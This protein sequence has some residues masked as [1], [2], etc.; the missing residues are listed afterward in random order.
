M[1]WWMNMR[2]RTLTVVAVVALIAAACGGTSEAGAEAG[3]EA[4]IEELAGLDPETRRGRLIELAGSEEAELNFYTTM[5]IDD[6]G[7]VLDAFEDAYDIEVNLYRASASS[8]LQRVLQE[9]EAGFA[10]ADA[11]AVGAAEMTV[12]DEEGVLEELDTP[13]VD[14][15]VASAVHATWAGIY[16]NV[17]AASWNDETAE[18]GRAPTTWEEVLSAYQGG[19]VMEI[20]DFDWFGALVEDYFVGTLGYTEDEAVDLFKSAATE[21]RGIEGHSLMAELLAGG[22]FDVAASTYQHGVER[23]RARGAPISWEPAV[24]P[25]VMRPTGIGLHRDAKAPAK[26]LLFIDFMLTEAQP[27]LAELHRTPANQTVDGGI[28]VEYEVI[29]VSDSV[30]GEDR[31]KWEELYEQVIGAGSE[32]S[33]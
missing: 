28:P 20:S 30:L 5:N 15:I 1:E 2:T 24:E 6:S 31:Q 14:D 25:L 21:A 12:F 19:L 9:T 4:I 29:S 22:E 18:S 16:L 32:S 27:I 17:F 8:L 3:A 23:F 33:G 26:A 13:Y 11:I 7:V 10:G